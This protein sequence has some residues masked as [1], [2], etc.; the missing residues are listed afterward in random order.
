MVAGLTLA[1][2]TPSPCEDEMMN[3]LRIIE[4]MSRR[5]KNLGSNRPIKNPYFPI[6]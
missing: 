3:A 1:H 6:G 5:E 2:P 4:N